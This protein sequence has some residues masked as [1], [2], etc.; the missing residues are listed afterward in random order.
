MIPKFL[1]QI[2]PELAKIMFDTIRHGRREAEKLAL[3]R[4]FDREIAR[5]RGK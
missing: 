5:R 3:M 1:T 4:A 2:V